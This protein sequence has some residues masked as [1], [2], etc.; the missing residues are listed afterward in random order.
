MTD[1]SRD[2]SQFDIATRLIID[3]RDSMRY[4]GAVNPPPHRASTILHPTLN[5]LLGAEPQQFTYGRHGTVPANYLRQVLTELEHGHDTILAPCGL[6]AITTLFLSLLPL[7]KNPTILVT[8]N[9]YE[10]VKNFV[11]DILTPMGVTVIYFDPMDLP[12]LE[13]KINAYEKN[14]V[15]VWLESPGSQTFEV[16]DTPAIVK[17]ARAKNILVG[18]DNTWAVGMFMNPLPLG[19]NFVMHS[20]TKYICGHADALMGSVTADTAEH[21]AL[22]ERGRR[23]LGVSVSADDCYIMLR[24]LRT[25]PVR[26]KHHEASTSWLLEK[27]QGQK[28]VQAVLHPSVAT[29]TGHEF[30]QRDFTGSAGVF[31]IIIDPL[32]K[33]KLADFLDNMKLFKMGFSWGGF[34][35]L[36]LPQHPN[37]HVTPWTRSAAP[38]KTPEKT[39]GKTPAQT[40]GNDEAVDNDKPLLLR[41]QIGLEAKEDLWADLQA[42]F[43]RGYGQ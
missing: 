18:L 32:V 27:L 19:V 35:S 31:A 4:D 30:W 16:C 9:T 42:A 14:L 20:L 11:R 1:N 24:G 41:I 39:P 29:A 7:K 34:E 38:W 13:Q 2:D 10:P 40:T 8:D 25:L 22:L 15:L 33:N 21:F 26:L 12:A 6:S 28:H 43:T 3:G 5:H 36:I 17:L 37:R 23:A